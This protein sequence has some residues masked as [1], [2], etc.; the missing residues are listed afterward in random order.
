MELKEIIGLVVLFL[1]TAALWIGATIDKKDPI[2]WSGYVVAAAI[3]TVV[4]MMAVA[5]KA[6]YFADKVGDAAYAAGRAAA[7]KNK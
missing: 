7:E 5:I 1:A 4:L 6:Q 2:R 3:S